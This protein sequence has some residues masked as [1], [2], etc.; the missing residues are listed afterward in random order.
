MVTIA[1]RLQ[2]ARSTAAIWIESHEETKQAYIDEIDSAVD[3]AEMGLLECLKDK[4]G[5]AIKLMLLTKGAKRGYIEK[6]EHTL[7]LQP[8]THIEI[9]QK[10]DNYEEIKTPDNRRI[11]KES[12]SKE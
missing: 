4:Q 9:E 11:S 2:S 8:F 12:G 1:K 6:Q 5:W 7:H 10:F 3:L